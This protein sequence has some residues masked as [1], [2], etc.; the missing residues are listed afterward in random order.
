MAGAVV[1]PMWLTSKWYSVLAFL[2][3]SVYTSTRRSGIL[4]IPGDIDSWKR[5]K[6]VRTK[7]SSTSAV[8]GV[9]SATR[10]AA[11]TSIIKAQIPS[12]RSLGISVS[13]LHPTV[14]DDVRISERVAVTRST[15]GTKAP[16]AERQRGGS[17]PN[18]FAGGQSYFSLI[19]KA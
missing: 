7:G 9:E 15:T 5:F 6:S 16:R 12:E 4:P 2:S 17:S 13:Q 14:T 8:S 1:P 18:L 3:V 19:G 10:M 11:N